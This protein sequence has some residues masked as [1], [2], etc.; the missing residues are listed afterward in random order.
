MFLFAF[1]M[2][3]ALFMGINNADK[4]R[5]RK[6]KE[7][8]KEKVG[9]ILPMEFKLIDDDY[10]IYSGLNE[11][12]IYV[13]KSEDIT[14]GLTQ[15]TEVNRQS[16]K[17]TTNVQ[18]PENNIQEYTYEGDKV[19]IPEVF[20][21]N[22]GSM[23][24]T[25]TRLQQASEYINDTESS[26]ESTLR[27]MSLSRAL[28][29][30]TRNKNQYIEQGRNSGLF[31]NPGGEKNV[32]AEGGL[33]NNM[34]QAISGQLNNAFDK[35]GGNQQVDGYVQ[36]ND[37][38]GK[39]SFLR[40]LST[41][42]PNFELS[43]KGKFYEEGDDLIVIAGSVIPIV[44]VTGIN[45]DLPGMISARVTEDIYDSLYGTDIL[46]PKG[47]MV[48]GSYDSS[49]SWG[50]KRLLV[51]WSRLSR[52][53]GYTLELE[54]MQ[55]TDSQGASGMKGKV[56][57]YIGASIATAMLTS[58]FSLGVNYSAYYVGQVDDTGILGNATEEAGGG[59]KNSFKSIAQKL[60]NRQPTIKIKPGTKS[61]IFVNKDMRLP[62]FIREYKK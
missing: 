44:M 15:K 13:E 36:Q 35:L 34:M 57:T 4:V 61:M 41:R 55:G 28:A 38:S 30:Q 32:S 27:N 21:Y 53:D 48:I 10:K 42:K 51:A 17:S 25:E 39:K 59:A 52:P 58:A 24:D 7:E 23:Y 8:E 43:D 2:F 37:Q 33:A 26:L 56:K 49:L 60:L 5:A 11:K 9:A 6:R 45:S 14:E 62:S 46:I 16:T 12:I 47:S 18:L 31:V 50:Q 22:D 19:Y 1:L 54:G 29:N 3:F 20:S 40:E